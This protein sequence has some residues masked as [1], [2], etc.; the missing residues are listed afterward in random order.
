MELKTLSKIDVA[1]SFLNTLVIA[2][3]W[4]IGMIFKALENACEW[5]V[6]VMDFRLA[7]GNKLLRISDEVKHGTIKNQ[8]FIEDGRAL[9]AYKLLK[10][11]I[12][13]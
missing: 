4:L 10:K 3:P 2:I 13:S 12:K 9:T 7:I 11:E 1:F 5:V 6:Y 8:D